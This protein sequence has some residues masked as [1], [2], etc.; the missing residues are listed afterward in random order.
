VESL[1]PAKPRR[2]LLI[3]GL[4]G[5]PPEFLFDRVRP[6][7]PNVA[8]LLERGARAPLRTTDPPIS[9]PAWPVMFTGVDPGTLGTYG[10]R[11][12]K[13]SSYSASYIP[14]SRDLPVPTFWEI[15]S[16]RGYRVA[17]I[18]MPLG[19]P[20]PPING[21]YISDFLTPAGSADYTHPPELRKELEDRFGPYTFDVVFRS[22]ERQGLMG[23][24]L[25]M[26]R[27]RFQIA[28]WLYQSEPWDVFAVHEIGT[29][30][31]HHA[32]WKYFDRDHPAFQQGHPF[33]HVDQEYYTMLDSAIGSLLDRVDDQTFVA[34]VSDHG[35][36]AMKGCFCLNEWLEQQGYLVLRRPAA[37]EG[38]PLEK[39]EV[40][41]A[42]TT[43]WGAGG[44]YGRIFF[45]L[46]GRE[47]HG[48][49][50]LDQVSNLRQQL[51]HD[52]NSIR[53]PSGEP[54]KIRVLDP[55]EIYATVHGDAPDLLVYF[56]ELKWRSAGTMGH[57]E[58]FLKEN[59]IGPDDAVHSFE[60]VF[61]LFDPAHQV[62]RVLDV[63]KIRDVT[64]TF[65]DLLGEHPPSHIQGSVIPGFRIEAPEAAAPAPLPLQPSA[66]A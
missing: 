11:H 42:R 35:S 26:T 23:E 59:D 17:V 39:M 63:Q 53:E 34:I 38:T 2:R 5:V 8:R 64:P 66:G 36:M 50:P 56:G 29:D 57:S 1:E 16:Q 45:N 12:R 22:D 46:R 19:Y 24:L 43:A 30:R 6:V 15:L 55:R 61:V 21:A 10:F 60:G 40:D 32:F 13:P 25:R 18:G 9:V 20:P 27:Q 14:T 47:P 65:L 4:D 37:A 49:V 41:W 44:Y 28:E 58:L 7:M 3:I 31:L 33:E 62:E 54:M 48:V 52:L 51:I